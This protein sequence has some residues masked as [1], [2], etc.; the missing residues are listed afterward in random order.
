MTHH[1]IRLHTIYVT[2]GWSGLHDGQLS[3]NISGSDNLSARSTSSHQDAH[4]RRLIET[5]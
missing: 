2:D 1:N 5:E 4:F 3:V